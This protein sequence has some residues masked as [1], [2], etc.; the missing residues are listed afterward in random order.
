MEQLTRE[1]AIA[2]SESRAWQKLDAKARALFQMEQDR[3]CMPFEEFKKAVE[4][5]LD[6]QVF[7][8]ELNKAGLLAELQG[9]ALAPS[10]ADILAMLPADKTVVVVKQ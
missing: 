2:F 6:R 3:L 4:E 8:H 9:K 5:T 1:Q 7:T 10:L